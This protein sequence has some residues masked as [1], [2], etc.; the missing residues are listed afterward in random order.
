MTIKKCFWICPNMHAMYKLYFTIFKYIIYYKLS[1]I[2]IWIWLKIKLIENWKWK[3]LRWIMITF[4]CWHSWYRV[5][6]LMPANTPI[7]FSFAPLLSMI[8]E[9]YLSLFPTHIIVEVMALICSGLITYGLSG[10]FTVFQPY[11]AVWCYRNDGSLVSCL[12][13]KHTLL[14]HLSP[15]LFPIQS[16]LPSSL[17]LFSLRRLL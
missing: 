17:P 9:Q 12:T 14:L 11:A 2:K 4:I 10:F 3:I 8:H 1:Q 16:P 15:T 6:T 5:S 7:I 13:K